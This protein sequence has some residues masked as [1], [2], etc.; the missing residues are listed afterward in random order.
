MLDL[1]YYDFHGR[2]CQYL[3][4]LRLLLSMLSYLCFGKLATPQPKIKV[5]LNSSTSF[6]R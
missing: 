4:I 2:L 1:H 6:G 3:Q 5:K